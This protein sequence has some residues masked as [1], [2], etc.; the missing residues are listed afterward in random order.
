MSVSQTY[1]QSL[2]NYA[3]INGAEITLPPQ[4]SKLLTFLLIHG[5]ERYAQ[6][7]LISEFLWYDPD[8]SALHLKSCISIYVLQLRR[9]GVVVQN[10]WGRGYRIPV[11]ARSD[12]AELALAA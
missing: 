1:A 4:A 11:F 9:R 12:E 7:P 3:T 10:E 5:P 8:D 6:E 2:L